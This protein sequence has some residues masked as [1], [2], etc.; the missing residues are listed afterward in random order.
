MPNTADEVEAPRGG[1]SLMLAWQV[2]DKR[3]LVVGA[4]EVALSRVD[5]LLRADAK[6]TVIGPE[7]HP[8][9]AKYHELGLLEKLEA[10]EFKPSDL[11]MY[12]NVELRKKI[13]MAKMSMD[14][15][16]WYDDQLDLDLD[17]FKSDQF[18]LVLTCLPNYELSL[19]IYKLAVM[20]SL[21]VNLADKPKQCDFYFGSVYRQGPLQIMISTNGKSPR[22]CNRIRTKMIEPMFEDLNLDK[23]VENLGYIRA[24]VRKDLCPGEDVS[25]IKKRMEWIKKVTDMLT[26]KQWCSIEQSDIDLI[27]KDFPEVPL[28]IE[29]AKLGLS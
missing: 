20:L 6:I 25:T 18:A 16:D 8:T 29:L 14:L 15:D 23:A 7:V 9:I 13:Q 27:L 17:K 24:K 26:I 1:G 3:V 22:L 28:E 2:R 10:R 21:P 12:E 11:T 19:K 4:G 5:H